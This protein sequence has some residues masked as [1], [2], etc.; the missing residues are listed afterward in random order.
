MHMRNGSCLSATAVFIYVYNHSISS[1]F[2]SAG[3]KAFD[4]VH[5]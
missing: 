2:E 1:V 4:F 5:I 3:S